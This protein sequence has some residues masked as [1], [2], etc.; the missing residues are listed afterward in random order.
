MAYTKTPWF[1]R[2]VQFA[3]RYLK[4]GETSSGVT[5]TA[6]PGTVTQAGTPVNAANLN[7]L[8]QGVFDAHV[9]ADAAQKRS[10]G[11]ISDFNTALTHGTYYFVNTAVNGPIA[12]QFG[13]VEIIVNGGG[14]H[15]NASN[16]IWQRVYSTG[17]TVGYVRS[18][19]N[20]SSWTSWESVW[21]T[22][23]LRTTNGFLE[24]FN[25][26]TWQGVGG[27]KSIQQCSGFIGSDSA[28]ANITIS[29]VNV[30]KTTIAVRTQQTY[31][32]SSG[33]LFWFTVKLTS[34]TNA[35]ITHNAIGTPGITVEFDVIEHY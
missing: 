18:K 31:T 17:S 20:N 12:G 14:T 16:W 6:D 25:G 1:D 26:S 35:A 10:S 8:E 33:G 23:K 30:A 2:A 24:L 32:Q 28:T 27:V 29:A 15:D 9:T 19:F 4:S 7:K 11:T 21:D 13:I 5:L 22:S 34:A 3:T